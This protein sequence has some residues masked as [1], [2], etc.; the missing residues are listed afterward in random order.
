MK[1]WERNM[2]SSP[3][4]KTKVKGVAGV[5][6]SLLSNISPEARSRFTERANIA[7]E[8]RDQLKKKA[9]RSSVQLEASAHIDK[10]TL[11]RAKKKPQRNLSYWLLNASLKE[12][13]MS[14]FFTTYKRT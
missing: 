1:S 14:L 9:Q 6:G 4:P 7:Q 10:K 2:C 8:R 3:R 5:S 12:I 13:V 11:T